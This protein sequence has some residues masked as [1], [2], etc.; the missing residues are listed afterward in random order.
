MGLNTSFS[1]WDG[2]YS[3]FH[4]WRTWIAEQI[5]LNLKDMYGFGGQQQ[6]DKKHDLTPLLFHSDCEGHLSVTACKKIKRGLEAI[7]EKFPNHLELDR[8]NDKNG[9]QLDKVRIFIKGCEE[10]IKRKQRIEFH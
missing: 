7:L 8:W 6:W 9:W 4:Q 3:S 10:A 1:A 2:P 5:G